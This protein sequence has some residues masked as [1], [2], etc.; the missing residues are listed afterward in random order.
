MVLITRVGT[1][2]IGSIGLLLG[3]GIGFAAFL[4]TQNIGHAQCQ[5][6]AF[7]D[8]VD[9][10]ALALAYRLPTLGVGAGYAFGQIHDELPVLGEFLLGRLGL[11]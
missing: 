1:R 7:F 9:R 6:I 8:Q 2:H 3:V 10:G 5:L 4:V 11:E